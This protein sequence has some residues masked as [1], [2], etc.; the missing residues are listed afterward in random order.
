MS[1][2]EPGTRIRVDGRP[3]TRPDVRVDTEADTRAHDRAGLVGAALT[4][5]CALAFQVLSLT[6]PG[7]HLQPTDLPLPTAEFLLPLTREP[8][9]VMLWTAFDFLFVLGYIALFVGAVRL[10]RA[11]VLGGVALGAILT[12]GGLDAVENALLVTYAAQSALGAPI[13]GAPVTALYVVA[14]LKTAAATTA[15]GSLA[16]ALPTTTR[17]QRAMVAAA[18]AFVLVNAAGTAFPALGPVE[19][20]P[21]AVLTLLLLAAFRSRLRAPRTAVAPSSPTAPT[22]DLGK[23]LLT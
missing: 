15:A 21:I 22:P 20:L 1:T 17:A 14:A 23:D 19:T 5:G 12:A 16:L 9:A 6:H 10:T 3:G 11:P 7:V 8:H 18:A 13:D 4:L 2:A